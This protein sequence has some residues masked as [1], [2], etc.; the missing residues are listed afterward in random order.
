MRPRAVD[1]GD[2]EYH[3]QC[4]AGDGGGGTAAPQITL[5]TRTLRQITLGAE[6]HRLVCL[7]EITDNGPGIPDAI[8]D[9]LFT[10]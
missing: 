6:R 2:T 5:R 7:L 9:T 1:S 3:P 4:G 8:A 10:P